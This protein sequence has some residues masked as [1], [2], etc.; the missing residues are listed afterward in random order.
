MASYQQ[1]SD[2]ILTH[3]LGRSYRAADVLFY[4]AGGAAALGAGAAPLTRSA[5]LPLLAV[6]GGTLAVERLGL[7]WLQPLG[8]L[9]PGP[10]GQVC[11]CLSAPAGLTLH[12]CWSL[13]T[14]F[15]VVQLAP[16]PL[17]LPSSLLLGASLHPSRRQSV[18]LQLQ[19]N[20]PP[21]GAVVR[22]C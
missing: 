10:D 12:C 14:S 19:R 16:P 17:R 5:R 3:L 9:V 2:A 20:F 1:R 11:P 7:D 15:N 21:K 22:D 8:V 13:V 18:N 4:L 6:F